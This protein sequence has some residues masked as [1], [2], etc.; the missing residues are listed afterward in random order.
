MTRRLSA[1]GFALQS[2]RQESRVELA[3]SDLGEPV[4]EACRL[5]AR[6][7][8]FLAGGEE[9]LGQI[10]QERQLQAF[11]SLGDLLGDAVDR[12]L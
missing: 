6:R 7:S 5:D 2:Q 3:A 10:P 11:E 12:D 8:R 4:F 9:P 1:A